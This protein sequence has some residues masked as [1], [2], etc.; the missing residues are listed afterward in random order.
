MRLAWDPSQT[1]TRAKAH[2]LVVES[3]EAALTLIRD[4]FDNDL[5]AI[6]HARL[7]LFGGIYNYR[8]RRG[9]GERALSLHSWGIAIDLDTEN[10]KLGQ[11]WSAYKRE[12]LH[13]LAIGAFEA[14]G[15]EW[16]GRW[17]RQPDPMHFQACR[18]Q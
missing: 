14:Q 9:S 4:G 3:I 1:V 7:D 8:R 15:M 5:Q 13:P 18:S 2:E 12:M 17:S 16:G 10:N 11:H 6:Q